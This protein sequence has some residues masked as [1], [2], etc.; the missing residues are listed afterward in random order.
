M[1]NPK[2]ESRNP[3]AFGKRT[4]MWLKH[5]LTYGD[6]NLEGE[7]LQLIQ[8]S[9]ELENIFGSIYRRLEGLNA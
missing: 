9:Q 4:A 3:K 6:L 5:V 2:S 8:E 7:R 1:A